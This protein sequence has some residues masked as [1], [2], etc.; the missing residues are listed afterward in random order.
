[1]TELQRHVI[2]DLDDT[3]IHSFFIRSENQLEHLIESSEKKSLD[4]FIIK[5]ASEPFIYETFFVIKRPGVDK[6]LKNLLR[7]FSVII[8]SAGSHDY[9]HKISHH[10]FPHLDRQPKHIFSSIHTHIK[11]IEEDSY[12]VIKE[13]SKIPGI[14]DSNAIIIDDRDDVMCRNPHQGIVIKDFSDPFAMNLDSKLD[15]VFETLKSED[16]WKRMK[17]LRGKQVNMLLEI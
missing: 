10:L 14:T 11:K 17:K 4:Y 5:I 1:M 8:W 2:L 3:L 16:T 6:F 9:V 12:E 7:N 15:E 13:L